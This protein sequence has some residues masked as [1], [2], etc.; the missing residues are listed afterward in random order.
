MQAEEKIE[1]RCVIR[2]EDEDDANIDL[3]STT[4]K[5]TTTT[6]DATNKTT[7]AAAGGERNVTSLGDLYTGFNQVSCILLLCLLS[8][9]NLRANMKHNNTR[10]CIFFIHF[11]LLFCLFLVVLNLDSKVLACE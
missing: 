1:N 8:C 9:D 7:A 3:L 4:N 5:E 6:V 2:L 10:K 11:G